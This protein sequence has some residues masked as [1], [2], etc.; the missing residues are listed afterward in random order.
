MIGVTFAGFSWL[1]VQRAEW[2]VPVLLGI[3]VDGDAEQ[4]SAAPP[5]TA[6]G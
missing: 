6:K 3:D 2:S 4:A 5:Q 1:I